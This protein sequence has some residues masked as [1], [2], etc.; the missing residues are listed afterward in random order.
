M[1]RFKNDKYSLIL[2]LTI[3]LCLK[4]K[5]AAA[6]YSATDTIKVNAVIYNGDTIPALVL[7]EAT[8]Y[9]RFNKKQRVAYEA[10]TKLRNAIYVTYPYAKKASAIINE[11][12]AH[13]AN[14]TSQAARKEYIKSREKELKKEFE[15]PLTNLTVYQGKI[16]M[17]LINRETGNNC[18]EL[19]KEY[20]GGLTARLYQTVAFFFDSDLK[21]P[22]DA[23]GDDADMEKIV[24]QVARM[25]G[26]TS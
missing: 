26:Y 12:N 9:A 14:I 15:E 18:Y 3:L 10:W 4:T 8:V 20:R 24:L 19:I 16:L 1:L 11:M 22:Y 6:Q 7:A 2:L 17:K 13:L 23:H 5:D 21:Q 25:Y